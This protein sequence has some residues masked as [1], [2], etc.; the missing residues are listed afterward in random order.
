MQTPKDHFSLV[1]S[2][3]LDVRCGRNGPQLV[4]S[5]YEAPV[6]RSLATPDAVVRDVTPMRWGCPA[7][8][9]RCCARVQPAGSGRSGS[10]R[11]DTSETQRRAQSVPAGCPPPFRIAVPRFETRTRTSGQ[12]RSRCSN[13]P[14]PLT[15]SY[16]RGNHRSCNSTR[17]WPRSSR[18]AR[19]ASAPPPRACWPRTA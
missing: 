9:S 10:I 2:T 8:N 7:P 18:A 1:G 4:Y 13:N 16:P 15:K 12:P 6:V 17:Q 3:Y 14:G 11:P 19:P 5:N